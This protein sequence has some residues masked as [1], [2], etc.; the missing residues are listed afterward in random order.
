MVDCGYLHIS[1]HT[2][3]RLPSESGDVRHRRYLPVQ[4]QYTEAEEEEEMRRCGGRLTR[5]SF[6]SSYVPK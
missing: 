2:H 5:Y 4:D 1:S 3:L 6:V